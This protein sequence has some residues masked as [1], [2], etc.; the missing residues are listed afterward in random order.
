MKATTNVW[1]LGLALAYAPAASAQLAPPA[2]EPQPKAPAPGEPRPS[3]DDQAA[4]DDPAA[5]DASASEAASDSVQVE[6]ATPGAEEP[7]SEAAPQAPSEATP[8]APR[9]AAA[10]EELPAKEPSGQ[11]E[12]SEEAPTG[13]QPEKEGTLAAV[14]E[15]AAGSAK[16][17]PAVQAEAAP[18]EPRPQYNRLPQK[19]HRQHIDVAIGFGVG[20]TG[21]EALVP[22]LDAPVM[23]SGFIRA[24]GTMLRADRVVL[25]GLL[26]FGGSAANST[27]RDL[28]S[29]VR[30]WHLSA[31]VEGRYHFHERSFA[32]VRVMA[33]P[34]RGGAK[35]EEAVQFEDAAWAFR[36]DAHLGAALRVAGS[37]DGRLR[38]PRLWFFWEGGYRFASEFELSLAGQD[39]NEVPR[40]QSLDVEPFSPRGLEAGLGLLLTY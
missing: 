11:D 7:A 21:D 34:E 2:S 36:A 32:Y 19:Y 10:S 23:T 4:V 8:Q 14:A 6:A 33:G 22:F 38:Q 29:G 30:F 20:R 39:E 3:S 16:P 40:T 12:S 31:G 28:D 26:E 17:E 15:P 24:G 25:A 18:P 9:Q 13:E 1:L 37:G 5:A 27:A 35:L